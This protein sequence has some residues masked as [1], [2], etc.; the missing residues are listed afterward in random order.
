[1]KKDSSLGFQAMDPALSREIKVPLSLTQ[2]VNSD[3]SLPSTN[4]R[5]IRAQLFAKEKYLSRKNEEP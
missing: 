5:P 4:H 2:L 1:M 3:L